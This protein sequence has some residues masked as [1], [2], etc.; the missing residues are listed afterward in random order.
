[1]VYSIRCMQSSHDCSSQIRSTVIFGQRLSLASSQVGRQAILLSYVP[2]AAALQNSQLANA[3]SLISQLSAT[4]FTNL[5]A[6]A[7]VARNFKGKFNYLKHHYCYCGRAAWPT[8]AQFLW[9][10]YLSH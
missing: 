8:L 5:L 6:K 7:E 4:G 9:L 10:S 1:M 3:A 2:R